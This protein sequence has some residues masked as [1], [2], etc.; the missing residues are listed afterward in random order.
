MSIKKTYFT[1]IELLIY[2][3]A[4]TVVGTL[5]LS[6]YYAGLK[7]AKDIRTAT[8]D[9][10]RVSNFGDCWREH[11]R[12]ADEVKLIDGKLVFL[13][14]SKPDLYYYF[15]DEIVWQRK[16]QDK[17]WQPV[18]LNVKDC[19]FSSRL[20]GDVKIVNQE[21]NKVIIGKEN[22]RIWQ[23]EIEL[24]SKNKKAKTKPL[25]FFIAATGSKD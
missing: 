4:L 1:L 23:M 8:E 20:D 2:C 17:P 10:N 25:F 15:D 6:L 12:N 24:F 9:I 21:N 11:I 7:N 14:N 13:K 19:R 18:L 3:G 5:S 16:K 22:P